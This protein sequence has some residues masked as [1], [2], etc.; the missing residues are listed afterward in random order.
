MCFGLKQST[1]YILIIIL[2]YIYMCLLICYFV[3]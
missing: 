1:W 3:N 2:V